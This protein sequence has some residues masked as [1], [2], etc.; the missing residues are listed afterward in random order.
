MLFIINPN[1]K[2]FYLNKF[3]S[4]HQTLRLVPE[5]PLHN[6]Y[7]FLKDFPQIQMHTESL[8]V[9]SIRYI[10]GGR[11]HTRLPP[12]GFG[13]CVLLLNEEGLFPSYL[14]PIFDHDLQILLN[15]GPF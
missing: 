12:L 10:L 7:R 3:T 1:N 8:S 2:I 13:L 11:Y 4:F 5:N 14:R 15:S 9:T 6:F